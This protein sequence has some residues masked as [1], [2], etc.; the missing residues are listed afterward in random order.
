MIRGIFYTHFAG[1]PYFNMAF[2]EWMVHQAALNPQTVYLRLYTWSEGTVTFGYNQ[3]KETALDF[4]KLGETVAIRRVTGGRALYHDPSELTYSI[5][6]DIKNIESEIFNGS[7]SVTS[8]NIA[9]ILVNFLE[10]IGM[11]SHYMRQSSPINSNPTFFHKAACFKSHA[12]NEIMNDGNKII[13][14][15]QRRIDGILF[16]HGSIK[17]NGVSSH[18]SVMTSNSNDM[19]NNNIRVTMDEFS[20]LKQYFKSTFEEF[21]K[22][23]FRE[24]SNKDNTDKGLKVYLDYLKKNPLLKRD[25]I[26]HKLNLQVFR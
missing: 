12:K 17:I 7:V 1:D 24:L 8:Q 22:V 6:V 4:T 9:Q 19:N 15:A 13:A 20:K 5:A 16:Q 23:D 25:L 11:E 18:P 21:M 14:S 3:K 10:E 26:K 2:D